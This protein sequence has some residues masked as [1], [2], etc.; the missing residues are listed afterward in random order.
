MLHT[1]QQAH[2]RGSAL[3]NARKQ[4]RILGRVQGAAGQDHFDTGRN[5]LGVLVSMGHK[6]ARVFFISE[7]IARSN[8][9]AKQ[10][11]QVVRVK[12]PQFG[13]SR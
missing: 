8:R 9:P 7:R 13:E 11:P 6:L 1:T 3:S 4:Q 5:G 12:V 10:V 2:S